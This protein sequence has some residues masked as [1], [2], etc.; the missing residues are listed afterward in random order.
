MAPSAA[1]TAGQL[2]ASVAPMEQA[3]AVAPVADGDDGDDDNDVDVQPDS[4]SIAT[5]G[6]EQADA[7]IS[8]ADGLS[9]SQDDR[10][11]TAMTGG[12]SSAV[13]SVPV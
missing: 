6:E 10:E 4:D 8:S 5:R 1:A 12:A 7:D 9:A 13:Q 11:G 3:C 2:T